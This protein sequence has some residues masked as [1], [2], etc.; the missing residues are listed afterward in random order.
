MIFPDALFILRQGI[1][2][3]GIVTYA[4]PPLFYSKYTFKNSEEVSLC[5]IHEFFLFISW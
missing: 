5:L 1:V 2:K 3:G 4:I